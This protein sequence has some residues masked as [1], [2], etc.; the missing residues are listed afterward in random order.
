MACRHVCVFVCVVGGRERREGTRRGK[1]G[2]NEAGEHWQAHQKGGQETRGE[3]SGTVECSTR[4]ER[5]QRKNANAHGGPVLQ[6]DENAH[7]RR[8][9]LQTDEH[10]QARTHAPPRSHSVT[11]NPF[12]WMLPRLSPTVG[13]ILSTSTPPALYSDLSCS[14]STV[15]PAPSKPRISTFTEGRALHAAIRPHRSENISPSGGSQERVTHS[16]Y[17][18]DGVRGDCQHT[19]FGKEPSNEARAQLEIDAAKQR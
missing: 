1:T 14:R 9:L 8:P 5:L 4:Q 3:G 12:K 17:H 18:D 15:L 16:L 6:A 11:A 2:G 10:L 7:A 19:P 13:G